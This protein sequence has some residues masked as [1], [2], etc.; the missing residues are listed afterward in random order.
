VLIQKKCPPVIKTL[1]IIENIN[2]KQIKL[3]FTEINRKFIY[4]FPY[5]VISGDFM[6][7]KKRNHTEMGEMHNEVS[8]PEKKSLKLEEQ[9]QALLKELKEA[10]RKLNETSVAL[11][12]AQI[13]APEA[14]KSSKPRR[15]FNAA[16]NCAKSTTSAVTVLTGVL[17]TIGS[18]AST[19]IQQ[20][21]A[22]V[23]IY[24][25]GNA[26]NTL[27]TPQGLAIAAALGLGSQYAI[28]YFN[29]PMPLLIQ[30]PRH[31]AHN[32]DSQEPGVEA[33]P[34][35]DIAHPTQEEERTLQGPS[36]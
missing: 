11:Y 14:R 36:V 22:N 35:Q 10:Q 21:G 26:F 9:N 17:G 18:T 27:M 2:Q 15:F 28:D 23:A 6:P 4:N 25:F 34:A 5:I 20:N 7:G 3:N 30:Q 31:N 1:D 33:A 12:V 29:R 32:D 24:A 8:E 13:D 16:Y 19:A